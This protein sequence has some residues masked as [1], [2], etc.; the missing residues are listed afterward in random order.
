MTASRRIEEAN[1]DGGLG[2]RFLRAGGV[3]TGAAMPTAPLVDGGLSASR[4]R[5]LLAGSYSSRTR[6][7]LRRA[8]TTR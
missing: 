5:S 2:D 1:C 7:K 3:A 8:R 6:P 4:R